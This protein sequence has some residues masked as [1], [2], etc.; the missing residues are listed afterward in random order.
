MSPV[1]GTLYDTV[2]DAAARGAAKFGP[3][4]ITRPGLQAKIARA[5][6]RIRAAP[7]SGHGPGARPAARSSVPTQ[8]TSLP[9]YIDETDVVDGAIPI[10]FAFRNDFPGLLEFWGA[11]LF[12]VNTHKICW[13]TGILALLAVFD[14]GPVLDL[15]TAD[16]RFG[17][18][19]L[20]ISATGVPGQLLG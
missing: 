8:Y 13:R 6:H 7:G 4:N 20:R 18:R 14:V 12:D 16:T 17:R 19:L 11:D 15:R 2:A 3:L 9:F 1:K 10:T 5:A